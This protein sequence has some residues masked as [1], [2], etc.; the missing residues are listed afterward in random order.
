MNLTLTLHD[1]KEYILA[2]DVKSVSV[3]GKE[4]GP[5]IK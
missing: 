5:V 4:F 3:G 2:I 1:E